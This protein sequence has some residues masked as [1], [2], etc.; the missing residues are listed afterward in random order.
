MADVVLDARMSNS[1]LLKSIETVLNKAGER[2]NIFV[3]T[4]NKKLNNIGSN[5]GQGFMSGFNSQLNSAEKKLDEL[6][7]KANRS[8][9]S[10]SSTKSININ[11]NNNAIINGFQTQ[12][13]ELV[14]LNEHY[15]Q[16]EISSKRAAE[17]QA[18]IFN[19]QR[20]DAKMDLSSSL[21]MPTND[22]DE[23]NAK[24]KRLQDIKSK[25][26]SSQRPLLNP[27]EIQGIDTQISNLNKK[28]EILQAKVKQSFST[29]MSMPTGNL[30]DI[31]AKM[32]AITNLR[33]QYAANAP[34]L[35]QLNQ[36]YQRLSNMQKEALTAG[37][38]LE[39]SNNKLSTSFENLGKRVIFYAG[40]GALTGFVEQIY[41]IRGQYEML[42]RSMG[43]IIGSFQK[44]SEIFM[45]IQQQ[46]LQSPMTVID[47]STA[48]K[49]LIAYNFNLNDI[50]NTTKRLADI[51]SALGVPMERIV[52][53]LGQ[54]KSKG[55]L[56]A[57]D[58]RD[59]ANAG[60][61]IVPKLAEMY[62]NMNGKM[63]T[64][65]DVYEMMTKKMV[66]YG[67]V[68][69]VINGL[70]DEG[71]MFFDF[72]AKQAET[73]KGQMSNLVDAWNMMLNQIGEGNQ[74]LLKGSVSL[75]R[76]L[77]TNWRTVVHV[78]EDVVV[79][80]GAY[81]AAQL[82]MNATVGKGNA[83]ISTQIMLERNAKIAAIEKLGATR[84]LT[85]V[86]ISRLAL[87]KSTNNANYV[88]ILTTKNL[89]KSQALWMAAMNGGNTKLLASLNFMGLLSKEEI[90]SVTGLK[91]LSAA[92]TL[93]SATAKGAIASIY[94]MLPALAAMAAIG[95]LFEWWSQ[96]S[97][98]SQQM[99]DLNRSIADQ[100]KETVDDINK[101]LKDNQPTIQIVEK[102]TMG[103]AESLKLWENLREE[104]EKTSAAAQYFVAKLLAIQDV[105]QRNEAAINYL[106]T[107]RDTADAMK[108]LAD[109]DLMTTDT[110]PW[111]AAG[112]GL[113][114]D[115][116]DYESE[117]KKY[118]DI[119]SQMT[120]TS[121]AD[122]WNV[123]ALK[124]SRIEA[125]SEID[126]SAKL[127]E[128]TL[129][130]QGIFLDKNRDK[131][132][133]GLG[134]I[135]Q[136]ILK[137][138]P[139]IQGAM[140]DLFNQRL[141]FNFSSHEAAWDKF[142]QVLKNTSANS[143]SDMTTDALN[144]WTGYNAK[145]ND[146]MNQGIKSALEIIRKS[147]PEFYS[148]VYKII[149]NAPDFKLR[150]GLSFGVNPLADL[151]KDYMDR[152]QSQIGMVSKDYNKLL[153]YKPSG[154]EDLS[155]WAKTQQAAIKKN[156][157]EIDVRSKKITPIAQKEITDL[158]EENRLR[159]ESLKLFGLNAKSDADI[160][161]DRNKYNAA[162]KKA[163]SEE[164]QA[165]KNEIDLIDKLSSNYNK[166]TKAGMSSTDAISLL[167]NE[168]KN[169]ISAI[170][171]VL[172]KYKLP[173]F[174]VKE[175]A[176]KDVSGQL[177]YLE[178]LRNAMKT[179]GLDKLKPD[180]FK[181]VSVQIQKIKVEGKVYDL[182]KITDGLQE[183]LS[184]IKESYELGI[185]IEADPELGNMF[186][187][188]FKIDTSIL[189][190]TARDAIKL[191]QEELDK[192]IK[193]YNEENKTKL[194]RFD[195][196]S[197][198]LTG[199][200]NYADQFGI[201]NKSD[202]YKIL[203]S[204]KKQG[205]DL[206]QKEF[207]ETEKILNEYLSKD[208]D[209]ATKSQNIEKERLQNIKKL[210]DLYNTDSLRSQQKYIDT[211]NAINTGANREKA[212]AAF[213]QFKNSD[214]YTKMFEN[215]SYVSTSTLTR[216]KTKLEDLKTSMQGL[217]PEQL[218]QI[219][220]Q[221]DKINTELTSRNPFK[222]LMS[223]IKDY[224]SS[225]KSLKENE[226]N[227]INAQEE[228]DSQE[229]VVAALKEKIALNEAN[230][231]SGSEYQRLLEMQLSVEQKI[232]LE[233]KQN[234]DTSSKQVTKAEALMQKLGKQLSGTANKMQGVS[235]AVSSISDDLK[236]VGIDI[237][238][239]G[240]A[241]I[242][243]FGKAV[244][245]TSQFV[246][247]YLTGDVAGMISGAVKALV[248]QYQLYA[249][250]FGGNKKM[251][252]QIGISCRRQFELL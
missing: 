82:V 87:L 189:P 227:A 26:S 49:Q 1:E 42:E 115:L 242:A 12:D 133:E 120:N 25:I 192:A 238:D 38:Q 84:S 112:E 181:E 236:S 218:K 68:M 222:G 95:S 252:G 224:I 241:A 203:A 37:V 44:G 176:G 116:K 75:A 105:Q 196:L 136:Q 100:A 214:L 244:E 149:Q 125:E 182:T 220:E 53:N 148:E 89:T 163:L 40:L 70:T 57:R 45:Q 168:Y 161:K 85:Q 19:R 173:D 31:S 64:T 167:N 46:A 159:T 147:S 237:G 94:A 66:S 212:T 230:G 91:S 243:G 119:A 52:Y 131:F 6:Q 8:G 72:Q 198:Q 127:I 139:E 208:G 13:F 103:N 29:V 184:N 79:V 231:Q 240:N 81:K 90:R 107:I 80:F 174:N 55:V 187:S 157:D 160:N 2:L 51:S 165:I 216:I 130:E 250:I 24:L 179:K 5:L 188:M 217:S 78:I 60:L 128:K 11:D 146:K 10:S 76:D 30:N 58:A 56:D 204:S 206:I 36:A 221:E 48:A 232:L 175:F 34:E 71:G 151:Q 4:T 35:V 98:R 183:S 154:D 197:T 122:F 20:A 77:F 104:I 248:G 101:Y 54:I 153:Q 219:V 69:K 247:S 118:K 59:F 152:V 200:N 251:A 137:A 63:V 177:D 166:L 143:F 144:Q 3:N 27:S 132:I 213:D 124:N 140:L 28:L 114:S 178:K 158:K 185:E 225:L 234:L 113:I 62:S 15:R 239:S 235:Q 47:L 162:Q 108:G 226:K 135:K 14:Q 73:L 193:S 211:L 155:A 145:S 141:D 190:K 170:N 7:N 117:I 22:I 106:K 246:Q 150:I 33:G 9:S 207:A 110:G 233:K 201:S 123:P 41:D 67:D 228:Y 102:G 138:H 223:N 83:F 43:A 17:A 21:K 209:F 202:L 129:N 210:N 180:A 111:G 134:Q 191:M 199:K 96:A 249:A 88:Q 215:L 32:K 169:S 61:A 39:K 109:Q 18:K 16:L 97:E 99:V 156:T 172:G 195:I 65:S 50:T 245:G 86:E 92:W 164:A 171:S 93:F 186:A 229:N 194:G 74:G 205:Q 126:K 121:I 142:M 23:V